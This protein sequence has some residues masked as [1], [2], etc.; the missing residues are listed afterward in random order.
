MRPYRNLGFFFLLLLALVLA[1]FT[2][3]V[4]GTPFFGYFSQAPGFA[5]VPAVIHWHACF[6]VA[7]FVLLSVQPFLVRADRLDLHR[8]LGRIS[9]VLVALFLF[10]ALQVMKHFYAHA[11]LR[12]PRDTVLSLLAVV[13]R[14]HAVHRVLPVRDP[15]APQAASPCRLHGRRR[16]GLRDARPGAAGAVR[17]G[18]TA[19]HSHRDGADLRDAGRLRAVREVPLAPAGARKSVPGDHRVVPA[20]ARDGFRGQP[21]WLADRIVSVR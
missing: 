4:P 20:R 18:R 3:A 12:F 2:P 9:P 15:Q 16:F 19:G 13:H 10:T 21:L 17:G 7:W 6:A 5:D 11:V 14:D 8:L 1:G